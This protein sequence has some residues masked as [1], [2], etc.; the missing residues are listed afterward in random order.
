V[1]G[2]SYGGGVSLELATLDN[3][4]MN[5]DGTLS[6]WTSPDGTPLSIA[7]AAP[8]ILWSDLVPVRAWQRERLLR[9]GPD[10]FAGRPH[11]LVRRAERRRA[12]DTAGDTALVQQ[13]A[14]YHSPYYLLDGAYGT[15]QEAAAP[16]LISNGF[17]DDL[18]PVDEAV[19]YYNLEQLLYPTDPIGLFDFDGGHE[20]GQNKVADVAVLSAHIQGSLTITS[21]AP[22]PRPSS[23]PPR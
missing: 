18:F 16:L 4:V 9:A 2:E 7:A 20:R 1:T 3:R 17:T 12:Y 19:R 5:A 13:I 15:A 6:P 22:R 21:R 14:Q 11:E 23:V 8:V 10:Q